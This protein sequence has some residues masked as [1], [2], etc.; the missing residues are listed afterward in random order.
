MESEKTKRALIIVDVQNDFCPGGA[1]AVPKG[2]EVVSVINKLL[3]LGGFDW[4]VVTQDWHPENHCSFVKSGGQWPEHC[5]QGE[6]GAD[7]HPFLMVEG[8]G[9]FLRIAK[10]FEP[11]KEAYSGFQGNLDLENILRGL[12]VKQVFVCGLATDYCIK[13]TALDSQGAGF[14]TF[15]V[16]DACRGVGV[17]DGGVDKAIEEMRQSGVKIISSKEI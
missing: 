6:R 15:V 13:A 12:N 8:L 5:V 2:N 11:G 17:K 9:N 7:L 4:V 3:D 10:G 16:I 14:E 1:L